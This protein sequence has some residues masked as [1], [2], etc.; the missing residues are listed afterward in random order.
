M[1]LKNYYEFT[2]YR[3]ITDENALLRK[4]NEP[5]FQWTIIRLLRFYFKLFH[6]T[7]L[8]LMAIKTNIN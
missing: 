7:N 3:Q 8:I 4:I 2:D 5:Y 1:S 6:L